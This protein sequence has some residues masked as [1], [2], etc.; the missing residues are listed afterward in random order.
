MTPEV[1]SEIKA[2]GLKPE[3][4]I[5]LPLVILF[6]VTIAISLRFYTRAI[7]SR[8]VGADD[9]VLLVAYIVFIVDIATVVQGGVLVRRNGII[10]DLLRVSAFDFASMLIYLVD[11]ILLKIS[12]ALFFLRIP[13]RPW[14]MCITYTSMG[15][16]TTYSVSFFF[17]VLFECGSPTGFNF[18]FGKCFGWNIMGPLN[19]IEAA[20]NAV[21]D[22]VLVAT[23]ILVVSR[24]MMERRAKIQVC[25]LIVLGILG[26]LVSVA[27]IPLIADLRI[28]HSLTYFGKIVPITL[29]SAVE[30]GVG[31][32]AISLAA[33]RPLLQR[34]KT[35]TMGSSDALTPRSRRNNSRDIDMWNLV[36]KTQ[37]VHV[38]SVYARPGQ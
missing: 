38:T 23:P 34:H 28:Y 12:I 15:L 30:T 31:L 25:F 17:V 21:V 3:L 6:L 22:W 27:R 36:T 13:Q 35:T 1:A 29:L 20:L 33:L 19:Y 10:H 37:D 16:Y 7:V 4:Y 18:V 2:F 14:Q 26:S 8:S 9:W 5:I 11:Q 24:T 32:I